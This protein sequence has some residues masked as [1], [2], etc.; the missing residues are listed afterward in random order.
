MTTRTIRTETREVWPFAY[1]ET[2]FER[3]ALRLVST[4]EFDDGR[5]VFALEDDRLDEDIEYE[6]KLDVDGA[7]LARSVRLELKSIDVALVMENDDGKR[8]T[9]LHRH[10]LSKVPRS[11]EGT[12]RAQD[13]SRRRLVLRLV[14]LLNSEGKHDVTDGVASRQ[15]SVLAQRAFAI[16]PAPD[17]LFKVHWS[18]FGERGWDKDAMSYVEVRDESLLGADVE[19]DEVAQVHLNSDL[20]LLVA[21]WKIG[22]TRDTRYGRFAT[23]VRPMVAAEILH[24]FALIVGRHVVKLRE[25]EADFDLESLD[26]SSLAARVIGGL[27]RA[28]GM[29]KEELFRESVEEPTRL[30]M[31]VQDV[32]GVGRGFARTVLEKWEQQ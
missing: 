31:R 19:V 17:T 6:F 13:Y 27:S 8:R 32:V 5:N 11:F 22:A 30:R 25:S 28:I 24:E 16:G 3:S 4:E 26:P 1:S 10:P 20:P 18:P 23:S 14:A 7:A 9:V 12:I 2:A 29:T 15:G 21:I